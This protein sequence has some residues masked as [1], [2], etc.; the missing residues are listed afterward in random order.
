MCRKG[1]V[2]RCSVVQ[3]YKLKRRGDPA[4]QAGEVGAQPP[5]LVAS[6]ERQHLWLGRGV[7]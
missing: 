3:E 7:R 4:V 5:E 1:K 6:A 2:Y